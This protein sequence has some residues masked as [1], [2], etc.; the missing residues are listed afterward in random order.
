M[1]NN[2][3]NNEDSLTRKGRAP[4]MD[5][6]GHLI[7]TDDAAQALRIK[8]FLMAFGSYCMWTVLVWYCY[9]AG[10]SR[11][12]LAGS[13]IVSACVL[14]MNAGLYA[15]FRFGLNRRFRDASLTMGQMTLALVWIMF[16][17][18]ILDQGRG[19]TLLLYLVV[20]VFGAF[21]LNLRQFLALSVFASAGYGL[22]VV[23]LVHLH[24]EYVDMRVEALNLVTLAAALSWFSFVG[25]YINTLRTRLSSANRELTNALDII[26]YRSIHD[27]L[28]GLYT[29]GHLFKI[30]RREKSLAD[31]E[32]LVFCLCIFDI[33]DFQHVNDTYGHRVG[34]TVLETIAA[35]LMDNVRIHDY[36]ARYGGEEFVIVLAYPD[37]RDAYVCTERLRRLISRIRFEGLPDGFS[38]TVSMGLTRYSPPE[39][40]DSLLVR[41]DNALYEAKRSGKNI[42]VCDP[43]LAAASAA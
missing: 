16:V 5:R 17:A 18:F 28:T 43:P 33:D 21:R 25:S 34:D 42:I 26:R 29:R 10:M 1:S 37:L 9:F 39:T 32:G 11:L 14:I 40:V 41:A 22:V 30:L 3:K 38:V 12:G 6:L 27:D 2:V 15:V 8:R 4:G 20:F 7:T 24:P 19:I 36:V 35:T 23:L 31:R 13:L